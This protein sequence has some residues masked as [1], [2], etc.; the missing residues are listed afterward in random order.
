MQQQNDL[1]FR[2]ILRIPMGKRPDH[3][4]IGRAKP[5]GAVRDAQAGERADQPAQEHAANPPHQRLVILPIGLQEP[6]PHDHVHVA[7]A[8]VLDQP[9]HVAGPMLPVPVNLH[10]QVIRVL[11]R[12]AIPGLHCPADAQVE[13]QRH[14][15]GPRGNLADRVIT[16]SIIDDQHVAV[17]RQRP[18][19]PSHQL[20]HRIPLVEHRHDDQASTRQRLGPRLRLCRAQS[21][22][23]DRPGCRAGPAHRECPKRRLLDHRRSN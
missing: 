11:G 4:P 23:G 18:P 12:V 19:Q 8:Q 2:V 22:R 9:P 14:H 6:R 15:R 20:A 16:R 13:W 5:A 7:A 17:R 3:A 1:R 21:A 10:R